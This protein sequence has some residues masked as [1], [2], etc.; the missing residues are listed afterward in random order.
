MT[1]TP[2]RSTKANVV[3]GVEQD[4]SMDLDLPTREELETQDADSTSDDGPQQAQSAGVDVEQAVNAYLASL[5]ISPADVAA[6]VKR[7]AATAVTDD[8]NLDAGGFPERIAAHRARAAQVRPEDPD[9]AEKLLVTARNLQA[10]H[11]LATTR[12]DKY[13]PHADICDFHFPDGWP[14]GA[15]HASCEDGEYDR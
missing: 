6:T 10:E 5:G 1:G 4:P 2:R 9:F 14:L 11:K 7:K 8:I 13:K 12:G 15:H 3:D